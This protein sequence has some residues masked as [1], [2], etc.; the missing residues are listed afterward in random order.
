MSLRI[1]VGRHQILQGCV[2]HYLTSIGFVWISLQPEG[3]HSFMLLTEISL[4]K[5]MKDCEEIINTCGEA[6]H[7]EILGKAHSS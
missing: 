7:T 5:E 2:H 3:K 1:E 4:T 6:M